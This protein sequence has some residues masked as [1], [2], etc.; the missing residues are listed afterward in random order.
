[1]KLLR[2]TLNALVF[3]ALASG[4]CA[5][6]RKIGVTSYAWKN[7]TLA[8]MAKDLKTIK[9][10]HVGIFINAVLSPENPLKFS[11][12]LNPQEREAFK[13]FFKENNLSI[14]SYGHMHSSNPEEI[15][16][17]FEF[18]KEFGIESVTVEAPLE[19]LAYYDK[20]S[21]E[22]GVKAG[23]YNHSTASKNARYP[24]PEGMLEA[25]KN[26]EYLKTFPDNGHWARSN[27]DGAAQARKL[28]GVMI[29]FNIQDV[30]KEGGDC[31]IFGTG[32]CDLPALLAE[33]DAQ[34]F[35][36]WFMVM[37]TAKDEPLKYIAPCVEY[38]R[39]NPK[40][41]APKQP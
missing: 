29:D 15:R 22:T 5:A 8:D 12:N 1:M 9:V 38:L 26:F 41:D 7:A 33:L 4:L 27:F 2:I 31:A 23:L 36:G 19:A 37:F 21:K 16:R 40:N 18:C 3:C 20:Y 30:Q 10:D 17:I 25:I 39:A 28:K 13:K 35:D 34:N 14:V 24:T 11:H 32:K 6:E